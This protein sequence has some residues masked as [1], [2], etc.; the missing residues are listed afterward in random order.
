MIFEAPATSSSIDTSLPHGSHVI[1]L[2][3]QRPQVILNG[4]GPVRYEPVNA[5]PFAADNYL[6]QEPPG[7]TVASGEWLVAGEKQQPSTNV[8][9]S[10]QTEPGVAAH[11]RPYEDAANSARS[12]NAADELRL[13]GQAQQQSRPGYVPPRPAQAPRPAP[14]PQA[15]HPV[16]VPPMQ[17]PRPAGPVFVPPPLS[18]NPMQGPQPIQ[19]PAQPIRLPAQSPIIYHPIPMTHPTPITHFPAQRLIPFANPIPIMHLPIRPEFHPIAPMPKSPLFHPVIMP[20][21]RQRIFQNGRASFGF[22]T[23]GFATEA[24]PLRRLFDTNRRTGGPFA[25]MGVTATPPRTLQFEAHPCF[26]TIGNCGFGLGGFGFDGDFDFDDGFPFGFGFGFGSPFFPGFGP[27]GFPAFGFGFGP[28]CFFDGVFEPCAFTP[29]GF[30]QFQ[31][32]A[33]GGW[34]WSY[35]GLGNGW[36]YSPPAEPPAPPWNAIETAPLNWQTQNFTGEYYMPAPAPLPVPYSEPQAGTQ[37][38]PVT[39]IVTTD[40]IVFGVTSYWMENNQLCYVTTYNVKHCIAMSRVDLQKTV[41]M[42]YKRGVKFT[43]TPK[44]SDE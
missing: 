39:E 44:N 15:P 7:K 17:G 4:T 25:V 9:A 34:G 40:G 33:P 18:N 2:G 6:W 31:A 1:T 37:Q 38:N 5:R 8:V 29:W 13:G 12:V 19:V 24:P 36:F 27:F 22:A 32:F 28:N 10:G 11:S 14:M 20:P 26:Q 21:E 30:A 42:N 16:V 23:D 35:L 41:D 43:L 3:T